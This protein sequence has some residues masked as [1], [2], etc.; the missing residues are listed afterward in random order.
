M[1]RLKNVA[2]RSPITFRRSSRTG[3]RCFGALRG[4]VGTR[5]T[6]TTSRTSSC[7]CSCLSRKMCPS[8]CTTT[9]QPRSTPG[10]S[11]MSSTQSK[12]SSLGRI[13]ELSCFSDLQE[14]YLLPRQVRCEL[15]C[16]KFL[17][18]ESLIVGLKT[19]LCTSN[20]IN[21]WSIYY[22]YYV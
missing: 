5:R 9:S 14:G 18:H 20:C 22:C 12:K 16:P 2:C 7:T 17:V 10:T 13:W 15:W 4:S 19:Q 6:W 1:F 11:C 8:R 21:Y 3:A